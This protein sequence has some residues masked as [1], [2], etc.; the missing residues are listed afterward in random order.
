M[1]IVVSHYN[2]I[3]KPTNSYT[4]RGPSSGSTINC[5]KRSLNILGAEAFDYMSYDTILMH[6]IIKIFI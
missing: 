3:I 1:H 5:I 2:N 4:F 6:L